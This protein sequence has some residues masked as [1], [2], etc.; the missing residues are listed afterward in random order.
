MH[1]SCT[2]FIAAKNIRIRRVTQRHNC[3][4]TASAQ[5]SSDKK[6]TRVATSTFIFIEE[7]FHDF[8]S[9]IVNKIVRMEMRRPGRFQIT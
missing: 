9:L 7:P 6:L 1:K 4:P 8:A 3:Q 2:G 5:F